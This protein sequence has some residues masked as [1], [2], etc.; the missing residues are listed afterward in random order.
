M[1][2]ALW[3]LIALLS[4]AALAA[5]ERLPAG[6]SKL[7]NGDLQVAG[8]TVRRQAKELAFAGAF[9]LEAGALEVIIA[10]PHGRVHETLL[11]TEV[12]AL[13][14]QTMLYLLGAQ[15]GVRLPGGKQPQGTLVDIFVE[16][17]DQ[18]GKLQ[19][20]PVEEWILDR[21]TNQPM[22]PVGWTFVGSTIKNGVFLADSE[23]NVALNYSVGETILDLPDP[24]SQDDDELHT[25]NTAQPQPKDVTIVLK[26][27]L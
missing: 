12:K 4:I 16:W 9:K 8:I 17:K 1:T 19:R 26:P 14:I 24:Q 13:Q 5:E 27:R 25:V 11:T 23:G 22:K 18:E 6:V 15:N 3:L 10:H 7:P 21:R 2:R 20:R